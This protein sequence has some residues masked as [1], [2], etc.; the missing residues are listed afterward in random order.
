MISESK[1]T[2]VFYIS[3]FFSD[4]FVFPLQRV[5]E[6]FEQMQVMAEERKLALQSA[7][8]IQRFNR[9]GLVNSFI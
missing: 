1:L 9:Y 5:T 6:R 8:E 2:S 7:G 3:V 4:C